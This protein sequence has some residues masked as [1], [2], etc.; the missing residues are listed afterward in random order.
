MGSLFFLLIVEKYIPHKICRLNY[1]PFLS[2]QFSGSNYIC[3]VVQ[4][5]PLSSSQIFNIPNRTLFPFTDESLITPSPKHLVI[6]L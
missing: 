1:F 4:P 5:S 2:A 3:K 6:N